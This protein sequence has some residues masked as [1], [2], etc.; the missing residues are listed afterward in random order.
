MT[1]KDHKFACYGQRVHLNREFNFL[2]LLRETLLVAEYI[3][4]NFVYGSFWDEKRGNLEEVAIPEILRVQIFKGM[5][6]HDAP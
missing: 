2:K 6:T 5:R 1:L 4:C 3:A